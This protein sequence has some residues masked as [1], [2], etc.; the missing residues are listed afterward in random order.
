AAGR[1]WINSNQHTRE[2]GRGVLAPSPGKS[3]KITLIGGVAIDFL[4]WILLGL[5]HQI[6]QGHQGDARAAVVRGIFAQGELAIEFQ[7]VNGNEVTVFIGNAFGAF[8]K[9]LSV[10]RC[11]PIAKIA[12][13]IEFAALIV[14]A[15]S[16]FMANDQSN[17][18]K[19]DGIINVTVKKWRLENSCRENDLIEP[20]A[21]VG[22]YGRGCHAPLFFV[23][24][25]SYFLKVAIYL[26]LCGPVEVA[27]QVAS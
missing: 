17:R 24:R 3:E 14:K 16:Q 18:A 5:G 23:D 4:I 8:F 27:Q 7:V 10:L 1:M 11:P 2:F 22:I 21:I 6:M 20:A 15:M 12:L 9:F 19:V 25:L 26:K 13:G